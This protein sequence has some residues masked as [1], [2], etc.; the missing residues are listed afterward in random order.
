M[1]KHLLIITA[2]AALI[3]ASVAGIAVAEKPVKVKAGNLE[4]TFNGGFTPK[5]LSKTKQ[6]PI[7]LTVRLTSKPQTGLTRRR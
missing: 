5:V 3:V 4:L 2:L 6:T 1:R 7:S